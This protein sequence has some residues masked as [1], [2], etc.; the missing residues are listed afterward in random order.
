[1]SNEILRAWTSATRPTC[2]RPGTSAREVAA[3][4]GVDEQDQVRLATALSEVSRDVLG[5]GGGHISFDADRAAADRVP[6]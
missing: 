4:V 6:W 5:A 1:M 3:A 2:S